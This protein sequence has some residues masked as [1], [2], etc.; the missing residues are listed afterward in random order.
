MQ[1]G[2]RVYH[3]QS[4]R[5]VLSRAGNHLANDDRVAFRIATAQVIEFTATETKVIRPDLERSHLALDGFRDKRRITNGHFVESVCAMDN[6][7]ALCS[8]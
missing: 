2:S 1:C 7:G 3:D 5:F 6:P 8:Q 4:P